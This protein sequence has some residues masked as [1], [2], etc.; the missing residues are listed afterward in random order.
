[1]NP[2][3]ASS[4][5]QLTAN[6]L[7]ISD[8]MVSSVVNF[9]WKQVRRALNDLQSPSIVVANFGSFNVKPNIVEKL[10]TKYKQFTENL[11]ID[12][13]TFKRHTI[14]NIG[15]DRLDRLRDIR[16]QLSNEKLRKLET[17]RKR[18]EYVINKSLEGKK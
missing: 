17:S 4:Y 3:K 11:D 12:S 1:M 13:M 16:E 7:N 2:K 6:E 10:H 14:Y 18:L 15:K 8:D 5:I 9:Y